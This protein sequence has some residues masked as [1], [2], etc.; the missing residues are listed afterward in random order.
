MCYKLLIKVD[1]FPQTLKNSNTEFYTGVLFLPILQQYIT[2]W[3]LQ[4]WTRNT[5]IHS[6]NFEMFHVKHLMISKI[7]LKLELEDRNIFD[8]FWFF[9]LEVLRWKEDF[10]NLEISIMY[11]LFFKKIYIFLMSFQ[12]NCLILILSAHAVVFSLLMEAAHQQ[13]KSYVKCKLWGQV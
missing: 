6:L 13:W 4:H 11:S 10:L 2:L 12:I 7:V 8:F 3:L 5:S 1:F 9:L